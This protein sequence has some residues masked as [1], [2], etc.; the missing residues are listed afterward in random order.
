MSDKLYTADEA[1]ALWRNGNGSG[2]QLAGGVPSSAA[3][4]QKTYTADEAMELWRTPAPVSEVPES[5]G[6]VSRAL[7]AIGGTH[8]VPAPPAPG[9]DPVSISENPMTWAAQKLFPGGAT[10]NDASN[11]LFRGAT[12][13]TPGN[14]WQA[15]GESAQDT[16]RRQE[17]AQ[18]VFDPTATL[19]AAPA[20]P[21][22]VDTSEMGLIPQ[23][24]FGAADI[25]PTM[26]VPFVNRALPTAMA[27]AA[28]GAILGATT[29]AVVGAPT[30]PGEMLTVPAGAVTGA[31]AGAGLGMSAGMSF[32]IYEQAVGDTADTLLRRGVD[33]TLVRPLALA[34]AIPYAAIDKLQLD[35]ATKQFLKSDGA[36]KVAGWMSGIG[37]DKIDNKAAQFLLK[38]AGLW[39]GEVGAEGAQRAVTE[40]TAA[41]GLAVQGDTEKAIAQAK[42]VPGYTWEEMQAAGPGMVGALIPGAARHA[43]RL[44][45]AQS[46]ID[47]STLPGAVVRPD[48]K[49]DLMNDPVALNASKQDLLSTEALR[50]QLKATGSYTPQEIETIL[51]AGASP[52]PGL[53]QEQ[54][55]ARMATRNG[56]PVPTGG[57]VAEMGTIDPGAAMQG[58]PAAIAALHAEQAQRAM[59]AATVPAWTA[60]D[61]ARVLDSPVA[62]MRDSVQNATDATL[63]TQSDQAGAPDL[64]R[65]GGNV[66]RGYVQPEFPDLPPY[67]PEM[68]QQ[69]VEYMRAGLSPT[70]AEMA[71]RVDRSRDA[72]VPTRE[73][74]NADTGGVSQA[75]D[76]TGVVAVENGQRADGAAE[77]GRPGFAQGPGGGVAGD[78]QAARAEAAPVASQPAVA[79]KGT[80]DTKGTESAPPPE[81]GDRVVLPDGNTGT[82]VGKNE[83]TAAVKADD[84][85]RSRVPL[86]DVSPETTT[87]VDPAQVSVVELP[88][89]SIS[90]SKDVP[91]FKE[92]AENK[93]GVVEKLQGT[94]QR[95]GTA[96]IVVWRRLNGALE[97]ITGRHRLDLAKRSGESTIPAQ[98][99]NEADGFT[100]E[101][102]SIFDAESNIR[103]G[104]GSLRDYAHF[105]R[106]TGYNESDAAARGLVSRDKGKQGLALGLHASDD[107]YA[108]WR[109]REISDG[110]AVAIVEAAGADHALQAVGT[111]FAL[112]NPRASAEEVGATTKAFQHIQSEGVQTD[113]FG[114]AVYDQA[115]SEAQSR[116]KIALE[117][118]RSIAEQLRILK[119]GKVDPAKARE[120]GITIDVR[121]RGVLEQTK[122]KL[123]QDQMR[124][125]DWP[126]HP[127]LVREVMGK[128]SGQ[129]ELSPDTTEQQGV[130][131]DTVDNTGDLFR[132]SSANA[133]EATRNAASPEPTPDQ[134]R[135]M[136]GAVE[137]TAAAMAKAH[138]NAN[139]HRIFYD[140]GDLPTQ[141]MRDDFNAEREKVGPNGEVHGVYDET[142]GTTWL[143]GT[144]I[145]R[146]AQYEGT[147]VEF[148]TEQAYLH[149]TGTHRGSDVL[150]GATPGNSMMRIGHLNR[151]WNAHGNEIMADLGHPLDAAAPNTRQARANMVEDWFARKIEAAGT[152]EGWKRLTN[153]DKGLLRPIWQGVRRVLRKAGLVRKYNEYELNALAHAM[154]T[155]VL[156]GRGEAVKRYER[157]FGKM[158]QGAATEAVNTTAPGEN[159]RF[160]SARRDDAEHRKFLEG[161]PVARLTGEEVPRFEKLRDLVNWAGDWFRNT[162]NN[163]V[164]NP[165]I[166]PVVVDRRSAK[167]S[168]NHGIG[169][170]KSSAFVAVPDIIRNGR[171]IG[172]EPKG[173]QQG[174]F[175]G[176][177]IEINGERYI[178]AV[179]VRRDANIQ[180]MYVHEVFIKKQLQENASTGTRNERTGADSGAIGSVLQRIFSVKAPDG[181]TAP[182]SSGQT[183]EGGGA[184]AQEAAQPLR[185]Q[186]QGRTAPY[187][188]MQPWGNADRSPH[189]VMPED[190]QG[191]WRPGM[192]Q[193]KPDPRVSREEAQ[194]QR[195]KADDQIVAVR[196]QIDQYIESGSER[197]TGIPWQQRFGRKL[198]EAKDAQ[199]RAVANL[200]QHIVTDRYS[201][202]RRPVKVED[203]PKPVALP[204]LTGLARDLL[205]STPGVME[206]LR[207]HGGRALGVFH[208][209]EGAM[210][211]S[212]KID[213]KGDIFI[214][215][216]LAAR[217]TRTAPTPADVAAFRAEVLKN[218]DVAPEDLVIRRSKNGTAVGLVAYKRDHDFAGSVLG[219]EIGH[220]AGWLDDNTLKRGNILGHIAALHKYMSTTVG[221]NAAALTSEQRAE[222]RK[223]VE[224]SV[225]AGGTPGSDP[226]F[227]GAVA[228]EM[229]ARIAAKGLFDKGE[230][231]EE[232]KA[233]THWWSPFDAEKADKKYK[234][235]RYSATELYAEALS[236]MFNQPEQ[237]AERAPAFMK[238][239]QEFAETRP[240]VKE[241]LDGIQTQIASEG[242][243]EARLAR[244]RQAM[245][246]DEARR[247]E[248]AKER[249]L[250]NKTGWRG[251]PQELAWALWDNNTFVPKAAKKAMMDVAYSG[252]N[253]LQYFRDVDGRAMKILRDAG[254][255]VADF[256]VFVKNRRAAHERADLANPGGIRGAD[257]EGLLDTLRTDVGEQKY[258][259]MEQAAAGM[260]EARKENVIGLLDKS[261]LFNEELMGKIRSNE[262][263]FKFAVQEYLD[264]KNTGVGGGTAH[265]YH[266]IG[267]LKDVSNPLYPTIT[268]DLSLMHAALTNIAKR[269]VVDALAGTDQIAEAK[270]GRDG[271][272]IESPDKGRGLMVVAEDGVQKG[273]YVHQAVA[274]LFKHDPIWAKKAWDVLQTVTN[275]PKR[276]L[277]TNNPVFGFWNIARDFQSSL[278]KLPGN[279]LTAVPKLIHSYGTTARDAALHAFYK[280]STP[281]TERM[282]K[283]G[284]LIAGRQWDAME[285][286]DV[287][288]ELERYSAMFDAN[289]MRQEAFWRKAGRAVFDDWNGFLESWGKIA[290]DHYLEKQGITGERR[291]SLVRERA[292]SPN[293]LARGHG[294]KWLNSFFMF[295]N[296]RAQGL[297][298][299][300]GAFKDDPM[301][302]SLKFAMYAIAPS[303]LMG[304]LSKGWLG[305]EDEEKNWLKRAYG[306]IGEFDKSNY[307]CIPLWSD[308]TR[309]GYTRIPMD[310]MGQVFHTAIWN[311]LSSENPGKVTDVLGAVGGTFPWTPGSLT[312]V[313][314]LVTDLAAYAGGMNPQD[315]YRGQPAINQTVYAAGGMQS[316]AEMAKYEWNSSFAGSL[317]RFDPPFDVR[318]QTTL[319][320]AFSAPGLAQLKRFYKETDQGITDKERFADQ[321]QAAE[322]ARELV[323]LKRAAMKDVRGLKSRDDADAGTAYDA[324]VSSGAIPEDMKFSRFREVYK[325][326][327]DK[328]FGEVK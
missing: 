238:A 105:F 186:D 245:A 9:G 323:G 124:W 128:E 270:R 63:A 248:M 288:T 64:S 162:H 120:V 306:A 45:S 312:P 255:D 121:D 38:E 314:K 185:E 115:I 96:P 70:Q 287:T 167:S 241:A 139:P 59:Q 256:G 23:I 6:L 69:V 93:T 168:A 79:T 61:S 101:K 286:Y 53:T 36:K 2:V 136:K 232:L 205:G 194:Q 68:Q 5:A 171:I 33:Q 217:R 57:P 253:A 82:L 321:A 74:K 18:R 21:R 127:D 7:G 322:K 161:E 320:K 207:I 78:V 85:T 223:E 191:D 118:Q 46:T 218:S 56:I 157:T 145:I 325:N 19:E 229:R 177:P 103:D 88:T 208:G 89:E 108:L 203:I 43:M 24:A 26:G 44:R 317:Y 200:R 327:V 224:K 109:N 190:I 308:G 142:T 66:K 172:E 250:A 151:V 54:L 179:L 304:A 216:Q 225:R 95:L 174:Y 234:D 71:A 197:S 49:V 90:L 166:G 300:V 181:N 123:E 268:Q 30:G 302:T 328:R 154:Y 80:K 155:G 178:G 107:L 140:E 210:T 29:G 92:G 141:K 158:D 42:A 211:P 138:G 214:G 37:L 22:T 14:L 274:D 262:E 315:T 319:D 292:G 170:L 263:Y 16:L 117:K 296:A 219:H 204:E 318:S 299:T 182:P 184:R 258:A 187:W 97:V 180:R 277:T 152:P 243:P 94:F 279:P 65:L 73:M 247:T 173:N 307:L 215:P 3:V 201:S 130:S 202:V 175:V 183:G 309:T 269:E 227:A 129:G 104:Q 249:G 134:Q 106:T 27:G 259:A 4:A 163:V 303:L 144:D 242:T 116:A 48:G 226:G 113:M 199:N 164:N 246:M 112:D 267:T 15:A 196:K 150:F 251:L 231:V 289:P 220:A 1:M 126:Q 305:D 198:D 83:T 273:Y 81:R 272:W 280:E 47:A 206:R 51:G 276:V 156:K 133:P 28:G 222:L 99:V 192:R 86:A 311:A 257:A 12:Q 193:F 137:S 275:L 281:R 264:A 160:S 50:E 261:G 316:H 10:V 244:E 254:V 91:Q 55:A 147:S 310:H 221:M 169:D 31:L 35:V 237:L 278:I 58:D 60:Q 233:L 176:A 77:P 102:A 252:A 301:T 87:A 125:K 135:I 52:G 148:S 282:L 98:V 209:T 228:K 213:L 75:I 271:E 34:A 235:Y 239:F 159:A 284:E 131:P 265:I 236:V 122:A 165:Q 41:G 143:H 32:G 111:R 40:S 25:I 240:E 260:W 189:M 39:A 285:R 266:Q 132:F 84:G 283:D 11:S 295:S 72:S 153:A 324:A 326:L 313:V 20:T 62:R 298:Q 291:V 114:N 290:G 119:L 17:L 297:R 293:F 188:P 100:R 294:T 195:D 230:I 149:E 212:G 110:K 8:I 146:R 13:I 76:R 67:T